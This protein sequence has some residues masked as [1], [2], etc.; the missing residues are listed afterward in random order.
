[1]FYNMNINDCPKESENSI[2]IFQKKSSCLVIPIMYCNECKIHSSDSKYPVPEA[3]KLK[4]NKKLYVKIKKIFD[5][6]SVVRME[7]SDK[8]M[9]DNNLV[10]D[11]TMQK[12]L[13]EEGYISPIVY[14]SIINELKEYLELPTYRKIYPSSRLG[15][16]KI[17]YYAHD[18][19][20]FATNSGHDII[21]T[22]SKIKDI[23]ESHSITGIEFFPVN[24]KLSKQNNINISS[25]QFYEMIVNG[26]GYKI[27]DSRGRY[28][29]KK[30]NQCKTIY[31]SGFTN[32]NANTEKIDT[33]NEDIFG[34]KS[35]TVL[36]RE[37]SMK[38]DGSDIFM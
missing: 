17:N 19:N 11:E 32:D 21:L 3:E 31:C 2:V 8:M 34:Y 35:D 13:D 9:L 10:L 14:Q 27:S 30:C 16:L 38:W 4:Y 12:K 25:I 33:N 23:I 20:D 7:I 1:M 29:Y 28:L 15:E 26:N 37:Y 5:A 36:L 22:T 6:I 18:V 24:V